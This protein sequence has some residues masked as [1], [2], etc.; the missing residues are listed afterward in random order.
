M[1]VAMAANEAGARLKDVVKAYLTEKG[2]EVVDVSDGDIF[3]ATMNVVELVKTG[4]ITQQQM[5]VKLFA[6]EF[7]SPSGTRLTQIT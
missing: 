3:T 6:T 5:A 2:Y 1:K 7:L 4:E